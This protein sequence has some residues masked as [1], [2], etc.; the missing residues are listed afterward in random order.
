MKMNIIMD[1]VFLIPSHISCEST[2]L[3]ARGK[4]GG[5][6]YPDLKPQKRET[7]VSRH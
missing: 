5:D 6:Y 3:F 2:E 1:G 4:Y 7:S